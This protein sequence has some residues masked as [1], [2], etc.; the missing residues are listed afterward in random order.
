MKNPYKFILLSVSFILLIL[1]IF[2][3]YKYKQNQNKI[4]FLNSKV[5][6]LRQKLDTANYRISDLENKLLNIQYFDNKYPFDNKTSIRK[7]KFPM[8]V[9]NYTGT[10]IETQIDGDFEGWDGNT[11]FKM[12]DG[13]IWQQVSYDYTYDYAYMPDVIIYKKDGAY[14]MKVEDVEDE[15]EVRRI[16]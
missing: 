14:Y 2:A 4:K 16:K 3:F 1:A 10:V 6:D 7:R 12:T 13:T 11:I 5:N 15:I 9:S 8:D